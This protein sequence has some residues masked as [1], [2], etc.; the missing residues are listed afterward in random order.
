MALAAGGQVNIPCGTYKITSSLT[1]TI[2]ANSNHIGH[3]LAII[4][5]GSGCTIINFVGSNGFAFTYA[6]PYTPL[7]MQGMTL[8]TS[9]AGSFVGINIQQNSVC[10]SDTSNNPTTSFTDIQFAGS[11]GPFAFHYWA[12]G[13]LTTNISAINF[14]NDTWTGSS[15]PNGTVISINGSQSF[16]PCS[17]P[18]PAVQFNIVNLAANHFNAG[19][20]Y[21]PQVQGIA[22]TNSNLTSGNISIQVPAGEFDLDELA[23]SNS[24]FGESTGGAIINIASPLN[25]L[26]ITG[27]L[28]IINAGASAIVL[29]SSGFT[30]TGNVF[31]GEGPELWPHHQTGHSLY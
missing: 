15:G 29:N 23:I 17:G 1:G 27:N 25:S 21:G 11:D 30:I 26:L 31:A 13:I 18:Q 19:V 7:L 12:D 14:I 8:T 22:I 10:N 16:T 28:F 6:T 9:A 5:G 2:T 24:Q 3:A 4:G 20:V